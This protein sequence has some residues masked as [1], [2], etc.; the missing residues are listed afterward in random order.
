MLAGSAANAQNVL[1]R[2]GQKAKEKVEKKV[3]DVLNG[4]QNNQEENDV[5]EQ[6][7]QE[8]AA[9]GWTCPDCGKEGNNGKFCSNCGAKKPEND[10]GWKCPDCGKD[11]NSG[12]F[13]SDCGAKKSGSETA[14]KKQTTMAYA[15]S[16]FVPGDEIFF[17][18]PVENEKIGEYPSHWDFIGGEECEIITLN[19]EQV[20]KI[21]G[22]HT[23]ITPLMKE[24]N[25]LPE[26]FTVEF[27]VWS[28]DKNG[29]S[30]NNWIDL[31]MLD[32]DGGEAIVTGLN[33]DFNDA[34]NSV[35]A[36][37]GC[38]Y[39][40]PTGDI[41]QAE[42][43]GEALVPLIQPNNWLHVSASFNKRAFKYYVNGV[44]MINIPNA[45]RPVKFNIRSVSAEDNPNFYLKNI[46]VAKGAVPLYDRLTSEGKIV[47]YAITFETGKADLKPESMVEINRIAKLMKEKK[48][49]KFEVQ[50]HCDN[51]GSDRVNDPLSQKRAESIVAELVKQGIEA[52]RLTAVGKGSHSPIA[53]NSTDEGRA[54]NRRVEFVKK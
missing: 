36:G 13:C 46:R 51:T 14:A 1:E 28:K 9:A 5:T 25:Y 54:K 29:D 50:G 2:L 43:K 33:P 6:D 8:E 7:A 42:A 27:D 10:A 45:K 48:D 35:H 16:D 3:N 47:T 21:S 22:W 15:K 40:T 52:S 4:N 30:G 44:R 49:I 12:K 37:V 24:A 53:D 17:D 39:Q 23:S 26:D 32:E 34:D 41:R 19:G 38:N 11:G 20:I 31:V 18:D